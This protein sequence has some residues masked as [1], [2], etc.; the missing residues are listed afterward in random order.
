MSDENYEYQLIK[1]ASN[2][3]EQCAK[4]RSFISEIGLDE[5]PP[6]MVVPAL[7]QILGFI[8]GMYKNAKNIFA[9]NQ[10]LT[11]DEKLIKLI[12][13]RFILMPWWTEKPSDALDYSK[14]AYENIKWHADRSKVKWCD[15]SL[16]VK[17]FEVCAY[18]LFEE[19]LAVMRMIA[20]PKWDTEADNK[21]VTRPV[22]SVACEGIFSHVNWELDG[23]EVTA[24]DIPSLNGVQKWKSKNTEDDWLIKG[25]LAFI[26]TIHK[27]LIRDGR[28]AESNLS[29]EGAKFFQTCPEEDFWINFIQIT[30]DTAWDNKSKIDVNLSEVLRLY[31]RIYRADIKPDMTPEEEADF[32]ELLKETFYKVDRLNSDLFQ[33][34][35]SV[36][37]YSL[38]LGRLI[39]A[40]DANDGIRAKGQNT[41]KQITVASRVVTV[42]NA[43][44]KT[45]PFKLVKDV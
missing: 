35:I 44:R 14:D 36:S 33:Q 19:N 7:E 38:L 43:W 30:W 42:V 17:Y 45:I 41:I 32:L 6:D 27:Q 12:Y 25:E 39:L 3:A 34:N 4:D 16:Y 29:P 11:L 23:I 37:Q 21:L 8:L 20:E 10:T 22:L 40:P 24:T 9:S 31:L 28:K 18:V 1:A 5:C 13:S 26:Y 2:L 15:M